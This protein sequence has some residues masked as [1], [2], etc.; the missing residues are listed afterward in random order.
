AGWS[1]RSAASTA[2]GGFVLLARHG[3]RVDQVF[4][5]PNLQPLPGADDGLHVTADRALPP[6]VRNLGTRLPVALR[7]TFGPPAP[8]PMPPPPPP[9]PPP[10]ASAPPALDPQ[11]ERALR[12]MLSPLIARMLAEGRTGPEGR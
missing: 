8:T 7:L 10:P 6:D 11:I 9:P 2:D 3:T 12:E 5:A 4:V 1:I